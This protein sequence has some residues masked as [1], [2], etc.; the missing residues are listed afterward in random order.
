MVPIEIAAFGRLA[1]CVI[2]LAVVLAVQRRRR[3][4]Y[5][6]VPTAELPVF[7]GCLDLGRHV[8]R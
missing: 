2:L 8:L 7:D 4:A 5:S 3:A 1:V 6:L